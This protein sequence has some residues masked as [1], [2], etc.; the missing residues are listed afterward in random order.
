MFMTS[1]EDEQRLADPAFRRQ[2]AEKIV[3]GLEDYLN[4]CK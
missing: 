2:V 3:L 4:L 1:P